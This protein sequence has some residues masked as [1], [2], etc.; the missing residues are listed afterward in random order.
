MPAAPSSVLGGLLTGAPDAG[1]VSFS[2]FTRVASFPLGLDAVGTAIGVVDFPHALLSSS[3]VATRLRYFRYLRAGVE[4]VVNV[5]GNKFFYGTIRATVA[6]DAQATT[7]LTFDA[8]SGYPH[9]LLEINEPDG[10]R[11]SLPYLG[12]YPAW[13]MFDLGIDLAHFRLYLHVAAPIIAVSTAPPAVGALVTVYARFVDVVLD[14]PLGVALTSAHD[15]DAAAGAGKFEAHGRVATA[16]QLGKSTSGLIAGVASSAARMVLS[17]VPRPILAFTDLAAKAL[18]YDLPR[19]LEAPTVVRPRLLQGLGAGVGLDTSDL[20]TYGPGRAPVTLKT[21]GMRAG[22]EMDLG[23]VASTPSRIYTTAWTSSLV[24]G[25]TICAFPVNPHYMPASTA[26]DHTMVP[27]F[28]A[29]A[30]IPFSHWRGS[31]CYQ[32]YVSASTSHACRLRI[33][34]SPGCSWTEDNGYDYTQCITA[35]YDINGPAVIPF[36]VPFIYDRPM[37]RESIGVLRFIVET[38]ISPIGDVVTAGVQLTFYVSAAAGFQ[39]ANPI[40]RYLLHAA[41]VYSAGE[42]IDP[43]GWP[44]SDAAECVTAGNTAGYAVAEAPEDGTFSSDTVSHWSVLTHA[45]APWL[46]ATGVAVTGH[47]AIDLLPRV[48]RKWEMFSIG[49]SPLVG[50]AYGAAAG[51]GRWYTGAYSAVPAVALLNRNIVPYTDGPLMRMNFG[52][53]DHVASFYRYQR[54]SMRAKIVLGGTPTPTGTSSITPAGPTSLSNFPSVAA[55]LY[56]PLIDVGAPGVYGHFYSEGRDAK[57]MFA[58]SPMLLEAE[59]PWRADSLYGFVAPT[60]APAWPKPFGNVSVSRHIASSDNT[61]V[62]VVRCTAPG[63]QSL[64]RSCGDDHRFFGLRL[65]EKVYMVVT[66]LSAAG[67][68]QALVISRTYALNTATS[69]VKY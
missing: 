17:A 34:F 42:A 38:P 15:P 2:R 41:D 50:G 11:F 52:V 60:A 27:T 14:G 58:T 69:V 54:G 49:T 61:M 56:P 62:A 7:S 13:D 8:T 47:L 63:F 39:V 37:A 45:P 53:L 25:Y 16:E 46:V 64:W 29:A 21:F 55:S 10:L 6:D 31:L 24:Q 18:G 4:V 44:L 32:V 67:S 9:A 35:V 65:P 59:I 26:S 51:A 66:D 43:H 68:S 23:Y 20:L 36:T 33:S 57:E 48:T 40:R 1:T 22:D 28:L 19:S 3:F 30:S 12:Q 5:S